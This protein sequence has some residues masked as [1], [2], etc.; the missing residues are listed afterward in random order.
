VWVN[1]WL[2]RDLRTAF[3][4]AKASG[5][6]R[7][8]GHYSLDFFRETTNLCLALGQHAPPMPGHMHRP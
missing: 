8:G 1:T 4:G 6:G 3:G 7:E 2:H 5:V